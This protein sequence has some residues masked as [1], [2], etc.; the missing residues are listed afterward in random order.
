VNEATRKKML[1]SAACFNWLAA[2][3][4]LL[5][6]ATLFQLFRITPLPAEPLFLH[7]FAVVVFVFGIGYY[8]AAIDFVRN[9]P[10][11]RLGMIGKLA[12]FVTGL[13]NTLLG[14]VSWQI[15]LLVS[16]DLLYAV[17]FFMTLKAVVRAQ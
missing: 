3:A 8:W 7:L 5:I 13:V 11:V 4:L 14:N 9:A 10:I 12:V 1:I 2:L 6:P 15:M 16:V 17:L